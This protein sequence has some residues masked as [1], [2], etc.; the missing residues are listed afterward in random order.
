MAVTIMKAAFVLFAAGLAAVCDPSLARAEMATTDVAYVESVN[1]RAVA[2]IQGKPTLLEVLDI[3]DE[4]TRLDVLANSE[5]RI[6]H[7][8]KE[9]LLTLRG[10][11]RVSVS[12]SGVT[13]ENGQEISGPGERCVKPAVSTFQGGVLARSAGPPPN[14]VALQPSIKVVNRSTKPIRDIALWDGAQQRIVARFERGAAS[15][16][17]DDGQSYMLVV[18]RQDGSQLKMKL[19]ASPTAE[20]VPLILVVR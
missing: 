5:L 18:G 11:L 14:K 16:T 2:L 19:V 15:P 8:R 1:G 20:T 7:Y 10:P 6:C 9:K 12:A 13:A 17:L 4:R 3:I